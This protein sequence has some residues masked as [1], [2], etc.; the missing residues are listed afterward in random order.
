MQTE[1][2]DIR[3][4]SLLS[5][6]DIAVKSLDSGRMT[7]G[8]QGCKCTK[9]I[10]ACGI[11]PNTPDAW[12]QYMQDSLARISASPAM[13][14]ASKEIKAGCGPRSS[15]LLMYYDPKSSSLKTAQQ[16]L[17]EDST[18]CYQ[19]LPRW[20]TMQN[21]SVYPLAQS[22]QITGGTGGGAWQTPVADDAVNRAKG[23][24]NSRGELKLSA[25]VM[26][27]TPDCQG[28]RDGTKLR[29]DNNLS[30]G[31]RHG[32][33]LHHYVA[34]WP[35]P[36]SSM[37][38]VGDLEQARY[39]GSDPR[40]PSYQDANKWPTPTARKRLGPS[41]ERRNEPGLAVAVGGTLNPMWVEWVMNWPIGFTD[42]KR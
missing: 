10:S 2:S 5:G 12:I 22:V 42:S 15:G 8:S 9:E 35:T 21:G 4:F 18:E 25:Q 28:H 1:Y 39:S 16:S 37:M 40:R 33:S 23:K 3:Q 19:T 34:M 24:V 6:T 13:V 27:P 32:V 30:E 11:H 41:Q 26:V 17:I 29:K 31:G 36:T 38:T 7:D 14:K 20:G